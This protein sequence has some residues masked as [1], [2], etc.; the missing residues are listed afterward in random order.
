M[1][2]RVA[3]RSAPAT[4]RPVPKRSDRPY[5]LQ[6]ASQPAP[7]G[8]SRLRTASQEESGRLCANAG[9]QDQQVVPG[10]RFLILS[11]P[12]DLGLLPNIDVEAGSTPIQLRN[13]ESFGGPHLL[14]FRVQL[15]DER[16]ID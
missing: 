14:E 16:F 13:S 2:V 6:V 9:N 12:S 15:L 7:A 4:A 10:P 11:D 8:A 5:H 3:A 1:P